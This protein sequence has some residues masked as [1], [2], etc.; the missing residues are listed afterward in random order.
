MSWP[1]LRERLSDLIFPGYML[2]GSAYSFLATAF[3]FFLI[4]RQAPSA[5]NL[6][7][8]RDEAF[9]RF[10]T[11]RTAPVEPAPPPAGP[12][13][14]I[15]PLLSRAHGVVLDIGPG[16]GSHVSCFADNPNISAIYGAEPSGGL[17][18]PL[19]ARIDQAKL[20][21]DY[22]ILGCTAE[23]K[24]LLSAL[25]KEGVSPAADGLFDTI[26]SL[27]VLCSVPDLDETARDLYS[28]L[29]PGGDLMVVEHVRNPWTTTGSVLARAMQILYHALG[30]RFFLAGCEMSRDIAGVLKSAGDWEAVDLKTHFEWSALP[31]VSGTLTKKR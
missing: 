6:Q 1:P 24:A 29:R 20:T 11:R 27:R 8:V 26:V 18:A 15:P 14:L 19:Q 21:D 23:K 3:D 12:S 7:R 9:S 30:W 4:Q 28:L 13:A 31:H 22:H 5:S 2:Y 16:S 25:A 17:H 10:W